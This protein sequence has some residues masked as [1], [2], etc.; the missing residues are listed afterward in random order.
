MLFFYALVLFLPF[1]TRKIFFTPQ[2]FYFGYHAF[3]NTF[4]LYLT[5]LIIFGVILAWFWEKRRTPVSIK[6]IIEKVP[7][8][9]IYWFLFIFWLILLSSV[10]VSRETFLGL[11]GLVKI[12]E[13][14]LL[15]AYIRE[16]INGSHE[17]S[18]VFWLIL[19]TSWFQS[20]LAIVQYLNQSSLGLKLLG[21]EFLRPGL[22]GVA[23][24]FSNGLVNPQISQFFPYLSTISAETVNIR[25]YGTLPHPNVLAGLLFFG[26]VINLCL[27]YNLERG[28]LV[29]RETWKAVILSLS[30]MLLTTGLVV[31]FS[32][33][34]WLVTALVII[35][36]FMSVFWKLRSP[37]MQS[38]RTGQ[39]WPPGQTYRPTNVI[40]IAFVLL[41]SLGLNVFLFGN[42]IQDRLIGPGFSNYAHEESLINRNILSEI[43]TRMLKQNPIF[44]VGWKNFVVEMNN[45]AEEK[46]LPYLHQPVHNIYLLVAAETGLLGLFVF[47]VTLYYIVRH[48]FRNLPKAAARYSLP[49]VFFGFLAIGLFDHYLLTIQQGSLIFWVALGLL[50]NKNS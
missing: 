38:L 40:L 24:F 43:A 35:A 47:L 2:S 49:L 15:F 3:Y 1:S 45:Y 37:L 12:T 28:G 27:L 31:T 36:W 7:R 30:L 19:A 16:N 4:Y 41:V 22:K 6:K 10:I 20:I 48:A 26:I 33:L 14:I 13:F 9:K 17:I 11:Y 8:D 42:Q 23:E 44:G 25:A 5:D 50:V 29:S 21:E 32:R 34:S 39:A 18:K 46:V